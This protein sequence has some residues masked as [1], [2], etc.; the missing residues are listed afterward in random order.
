VNASE[1]TCH[2][3]DVEELITRA[4]AELEAAEA[5]ERAKDEH[6]R[7]LEEHYASARRVCEEAQA[8]ARTRQDEVATLEA[9]IREL[10]ECRPMETAPRDGTRILLRR[11]PEFSWGG[12]FVMARSFDGTDWLST[13][14]SE[15]T[16][17]F[18]GW[19]PLPSTLFEQGRVLP[20]P[21]PSTEGGDHG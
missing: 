14:L 7:E 2:E 19:W 5:R 1:L 16:S 21:L 13:Q 11:A 18:I 6:I 15:P 20:L 4:N 8:I 9:R 3:G 17:H 12:W 10:T